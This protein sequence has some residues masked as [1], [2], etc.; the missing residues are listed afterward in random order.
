MYENV[1][2]LHYAEMVKFPKEKFE[3]KNQDN[4]G[5]FILKCQTKK[6][7]FFKNTIRRPFTPFLNDVKFN[8]LKKKM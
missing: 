2:R 8:S 5:F 3:N 6:D 4:G 1:S 7:F